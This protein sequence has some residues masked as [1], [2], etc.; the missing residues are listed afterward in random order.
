LWFRDVYGVD[1][2]SIA[3]DEDGTLFAGD[4]AGTVWLLDT[5]DHDGTAH[6][7]VTLWTPVEDDDMPLARKEPYDLQILLDTGAEA[8]AVAV[9]QDGSGTAATTLSATTSGAQMYREDLAD[10]LSPAIGWQ[11]RVTCSCSTFKWYHWTLSYRYHPQHRLF[12]D[13]LP[14]IGTQ[15]AW[16]RFIRLKAILFNTVRVSV[17]E[18][19]TLLETQDITTYT[20]GVLDVFRIRLGREVKGRQLRVQFAAVNS[21][22]IGDVGFEPYYVEMVY[23]GSGST[24]EKTT[25]QALMPAERVGGGQEPQ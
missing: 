17:Y 12:L 2:R 18:G 3:A 22:A 5:G 15:Y 20:S 11:L 7:S 9:H 6:I 8:A 16:A 4:T 25:R 24:T 14:D 10:T 23:R 1:W 19:S 13:W 21:T